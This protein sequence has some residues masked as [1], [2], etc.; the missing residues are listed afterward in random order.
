MKQNLNDTILWCR[1]EDFWCILETNYHCTDVEISE[2]IAY[3]V[4]EVFNLLSTTP[5][6]LYFYMSS[7]V[8]RDFKNG[9]LVI[10]LS[11]KSCFNSKIRAS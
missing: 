1:Y 4:E 7:Q 2:I 11:I 9:E 5:K 10:W 8:E 3:K 6:A